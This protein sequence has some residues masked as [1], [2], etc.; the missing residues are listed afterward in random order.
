MKVESQHVLESI[1]RELAFYRKRV[2]E[3]IFFA[4]AVDVAIV[5]GDKTLPIAESYPLVAAVAM[6]LLFLVVALAAFVLGREYSERIHHLKN[7]RIDLV[8]EGYGDVFPQRGRR[9]VSEIGTLVLLVSI[10]S[11]AGIFLAWVDAWESVSWWVRSSILATGVGFGVI[12]CC[13]LFGPERP[14]QASRS[15]R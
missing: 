7:T 15:T 12:A 5:T 1:D 2:G 14:A 9:H 10:L 8:K 6:S 4:L 11:I 3:V 13:V